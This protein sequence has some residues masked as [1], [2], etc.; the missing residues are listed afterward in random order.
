[1]VP[2]VRCWL[3]LL[4]LCWIG[5]IQAADADVV[6]LYRE[7]AVMQ[8]QLA[9]Y[10]AAGSV[11]LTNQRLGRSD[12][13][14]EWLLAGIYRDFGM[15]RHAERSFRR[16]IAQGATTVQRNQAWLALAS[17]RF[18]RGQV[19]AAEDALAYISQDIPKELLLDRLRLQTSVL[20]A[21]QQQNRAIQLL[22]AAEV[23]NLRDPVLDY[24][25]A[26]ALMAVQMDDKAFEV[27]QSLGKIKP[28]SEEAGA[29][30]DLANLR[31]AELQARQGQVVEALTS[32]QRVSP[33]GPYQVASLHL[34][35]ELYEGLKRWDAARADWLALQR[36]ASTEVVPAEAWV[37]AAYSAQQA[38]DLPAA[39][40]GFREA[41]PLHEQEKK[42]LN[43]A[44]QWLESNDWLEMLDGRDLPL[45]ADTLWLRYLPELM[46]GHRFG[47]ALSDYQDARRLDRQ[48]AM[49]APTLPQYQSVLAERRQAFEAVRGQ[50]D[51]DA[52]DLRI[53]KLQRQSTGLTQQWKRTGDGRQSS[54]GVTEA[55]RR[56]MERLAR[57][58][59]RIRAL[60]AGDDKAPLLQRHDLLRGLLI[61]DSN[62][63][64]LLEREKLM[65]SQQ[66]VL[67]GLEQAV[68][69][70]QR[71]MKRLAE[72]PAEF[73]QAS[74]MLDA[75]PGRIDELRS[76]LRAVMQ[77]RRQ[78]LLEQ[79]RERLLQRIDE[80]QL[81]QDR[82][83]YGVAYLLDRASV[84]QADKP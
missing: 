76:G 58:E 12:A 75:M 44:L 36:K 71:L 11:L 24:N 47:T 39:V 1:M 41:I 81:N 19:E 63:T 43:Q 72:K 7:T 80:L 62:Q 4:S 73:R 31:L 61:W 5:L 8:Q 20:L 22:G 77:Q 3:S 42:Q 74:A 64:A 34:R 78:Q 45:S 33:D 28:R 67:S 48:L 16:I 68:S 66:A 79:I 51:A 50:W 55:Q 13:A 30:Q 32:L 65:E 35:A 59:V 84:D 9:D 49:I 14:G 40:Q 27:L 15:S 56:M 69:N 60:P 26:V 57:V 83:R 38:G 54:I 6:Q 10:S 18:R 53:R 2:G 46:S 17:A 82:A 70:R 52:L 37:R 23:R 21:R 29:I 25:Y